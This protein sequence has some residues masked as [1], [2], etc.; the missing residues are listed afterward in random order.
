MS[1]TIDQWHRR[2]QQQARWTQDLRKYIFQKCAIERAK[3]VLDVGCGTGVL[4]EEITRTLETPMYGIDIDFAA[5][6]YARGFAS[7]AAYSLADARSLPFHT[8][9]FDISLCHF[10]LLWVSSAQDILSEMARV[11]LPGGYVVALAEPDYGGRIDF[12]DELSIIGRWQAEALEYQ[13]ADPLMGRKL[14]YLFSLAGLVDIEVGIL[15]AQWQ[16]DPSLSDVDLEWKVLDSD[17]KDHPTFQR[18]KSGIRVLDNASRQAHSRI[19]FVPVFYAL[20]H[21]PGYPAAGRPSSI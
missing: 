10:L 18:R 1:L 12:P 8:A 14:R 15:G 4:E 3:R 5:L 21:A 6:E 11:T 19:L 13:G 20:G 16:K 2:Y 9:T 7:R 17:L